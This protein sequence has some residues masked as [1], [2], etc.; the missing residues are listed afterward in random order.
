MTIESPGRACAPLQGKNETKESEQVGKIKLDSPVKKARNLPVK[1]VLNPPGRL[2]DDLTTPL[3]EE[4][5]PQQ[6]QEKVAGLQL[7]LVS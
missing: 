7:P 1:M 5:E 6:G 3:P 2:P 4:E